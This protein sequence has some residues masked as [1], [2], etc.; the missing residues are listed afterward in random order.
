MEG[1]EKGRG[2]GGK[3]Q[4]ERFL[5][6][7]KYSLFLSR[8][9][10]ADCATIKHLSAHPLNLVIVSLWPRRSKTSE[11]SGNTL[12]SSHV[13]EKVEGEKGG[14][15]WIYLCV[16]KLWP[17]AFTAGVNRRTLERPL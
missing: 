1:V 3:R 14:K 15:D 13:W 10:R 16:S 4:R 6:V 2:R 12:C 5:S 9:R 11:I 17:R 8:R 7:E